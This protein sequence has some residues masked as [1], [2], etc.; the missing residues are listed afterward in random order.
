MF[1]VLLLFQLY[2]YKTGSLRSTGKGKGLGCH[3]IS[4]SIHLP[5]ETKSYFPGH[6]HGYGLLH[7]GSFEYPGE[8]LSVGCTSH[9][10]LGL[11]GTNNVS[12][13]RSH[14]CSP[15]WCHCSALSAEVVVEVLPS[16]A[17]DRGAGVVVEV[18]PSIGRLKSRFRE[19]LAQDR[20][21]SDKQKSRL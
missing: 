17:R 1:F 15:H 7:F 13:P 6:L 8:G 20:G 10:G 16:L 19:S 12:I 21:D 3:R 5:C 4:S 2:T 9:P 18:L 11:G 14:S